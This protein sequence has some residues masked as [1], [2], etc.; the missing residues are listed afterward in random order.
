MITF[1][2]HSVGLGDN[3]AELVFQTI[4]MQLWADDYWISR[5]CGV[6]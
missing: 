4:Q 2:S 3:A 6:C 1:A 5:T